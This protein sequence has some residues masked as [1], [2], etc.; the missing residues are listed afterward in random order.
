MKSYHF[1]FLI[2]AFFMSTEAVAQLS[3]GVKS[4][5][6]RAWQDYGDVILP[7]WA[8]THIHSYQASVLLHYQLNKHLEIGIEPGLVQRGA[9]CE[10]GFSTFNSDTEIHLNYAELPLLMTFKVPFCQDRLEAYAKGGVGTS[11]I[12]TGYRQVNVFSSNEDP[13]QTK[14]N[15]TGF[16][17]PRRWDIGFHGG[18]G[19]SCRIG[20]GKILL[21]STFYGGMRDFAAPLSSQNRSIFVGLGYLYSL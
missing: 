9:A 3:V 15:F 4:G 14:L 11:F 19:I 6:V 8:Q 18:M 2:F 16:R 10:P 21:E 17:A 7:E 1:F 13:Q 5:Y 12:L 20:T